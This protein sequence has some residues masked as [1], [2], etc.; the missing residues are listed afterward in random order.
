M[1]K[2]M[3]VNNPNEPKPSQTPKS[4]LTW[5]NRLILS[6]VILSI[7]F[8]TSMFSQNMDLTLDDIHTPVIGTR[9]IA[10]P[11]K[12]DSIENSVEYILM[13]EKFNIKSKILK[14]TIWYRISAKN[15]IIQDIIFMVD[16][17]YYWSKNQ[18][19][20]KNAV[21]FMCNDTCY[22]FIPGTRLKYTDSIYNKFPCMISEGDFKYAYIDNQYIYVNHDKN[23]YNIQIKDSDCF[24]YEKSLNGLNF[25]TNYSIG[26]TIPLN[27]QPYIL[28]NIDWENNTIS[29]EYIPNN[30]HY[31]KIYIDSWDNYLKYFKSNNYL[32][33]DFWGTWCGTCIEGFPIL[34]KLYKEYDQLISFLSICYDDKENFL[35]AQSLLKSNEIYWPNE[36]ISFN[37]NNS[38][39]SMLNI[40]S[41]PS[42]ILINKQRDIIFRLS[43]DKS[44]PDISRIFNSI[45]HSDTEDHQKIIL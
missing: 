43:G 38:L 11:L 16:S 2:V 31:N 5:H 4:C 12:Y 22:F 37:Q 26:D 20:D 45:R 29:F 9:F 7:F 27:Y 14:D 24:H 33:I 42:F 19:Y 28:R 32:F 10:R 8:V 25:K 15:R 17:V 18:S 30:F 3:T 21:R 41:F 23:G 44:F 36:F 6:Y 39:I 1:D 35:K 40:N 13:G 34:K